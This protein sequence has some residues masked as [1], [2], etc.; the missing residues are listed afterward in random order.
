MD[1]IKMNYNYIFPSTS[2]QKYITMGR[3]YIYDHLV[4]LYSRHFKN[5]KISVVPVQ[6]FEFFYPVT[7]DTSD[8]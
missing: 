7:L 2:T 6:R 4:I 8:N 1:N 3:I 5:F